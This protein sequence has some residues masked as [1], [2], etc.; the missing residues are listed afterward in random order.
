M[1]VSQPA[2][3]AFT[4]GRRI[5]SG[6][7]G[8]VAVAVKRA[9]EQGQAGLLVFED[10]TGR[11]IDFD[12][13][14]S[15]AEI[16]ARADA[17]AVPAAGQSPS[18]EAPRGR[19]RPKL[20][21]VGRE[22]T[23]LPRHWDWLGRQPGGASVALRKLIDEKR[24]ARGADGR[25]RAA[26]A[27]ADRVMG[28][29][30]GD[31]LNYEEASRALYRREGDRFASLVADWPVDVRTYVLRLAAPAFARDEAAINAQTSNGATLT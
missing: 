3:S 22:V 23:L 18:G 8:D 31:L 29:L 26:Q 30:A 7:R 12:L 4:Q 19:G 25:A 13:R 6:P 24:A 2:F 1:T 27:A 21:V 28:V 5:A 15:D 10:A 17:A 14:G 16:R 11:E 20:G 9:T